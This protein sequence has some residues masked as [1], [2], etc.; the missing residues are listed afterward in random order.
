[1][2][3]VLLIPKKSVDFEMFKKVINTGL[4]THYGSEKAMR[5]SIKD[6]L[7]LYGVS[8]YKLIDLQEFERYV[9]N[10][11]LGDDW[12]KYVTIEKEEKEEED[13]KR[14]SLFLKIAYIVVFVIS[15]YIFTLTLM[16]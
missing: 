3:F 11:K 14:M 9:E 6:N 1:M 13:E 4:E 8:R 7:A 10:C 15:I 16:S 2:D 12:I 5:E